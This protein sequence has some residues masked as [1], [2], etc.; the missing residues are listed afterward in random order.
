MNLRS[1]L[2]EFRL[3]S[4]WICALIMLYRSA[5]RGERDLSLQARKVGQS[6]R[7]STHQTL[8]LGPSV[9]SQ[10][11]PVLHTNL[12]FKADVVSED[13]GVLVEPCFVRYRAE[14][15]IN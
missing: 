15:D 9:V 2:V 7:L 1:Y 4:F 8:G 11:S 6:S 10:T 3:D 12:V 13:F 14:H 5:R